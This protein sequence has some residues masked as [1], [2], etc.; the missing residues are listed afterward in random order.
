MKRLANQL[1]LQKS[2]NRKALSL[3]VTAGFPEVET[4][5]PLILALAGAGADM[6]ELGIPFSDPIADGPTIQESSETALR[7]GMTLE[8]TLEIA[9]AVRASSEVPVLLM[10]YAN[11]IYAFGVTRFL[12]RCASIG[13]DGTIIPDLSL[14]EG[15]DYR[16]CAAAHGVASV[17]M[18]A[19]TSANERLEALDEATSGFLYCVSV[20]GITGA[21]TGMSPATVDYLKRAR[22]HVR[23]HPLV[24]GFGIATP[25]DARAA[26]CHSDGVVVGS[27]LVNILREHSGPGLIER[28]ADFTRSL[29]GA[30]DA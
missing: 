22:A 28:A 21:R 29:R 26:A 13:V 12:Q 24:V 19:P 25:D 14:E 20:A 23:R 9:R 1:A 2:R 6:I 5:L 30:L 10:G 16:S 15:A 17:L 11:P 3:Y 27:A 8:K 7:N 18:A 4:T